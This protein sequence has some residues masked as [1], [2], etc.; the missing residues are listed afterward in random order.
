MWNATEDSP[1][2]AVNS[3]S[4]FF[5]MDSTLICRSHRGFSQR[6]VVLSLGVCSTAWLGSCESRLACSAAVETNLAVWLSVSVVTLDLANADCTSAKL[7]EHTSE[8]PFRWEASSSKS[9]RPSARFVSMKL[10][11]PRSECGSTDRKYF[12]PW[13]SCVWHRIFCWLAHICQ[14]W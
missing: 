4:S 14:V 11:I 1:G 10:R 13:S 9:S 8:G 2:G 12:C 7:N 6:H 5:G 3:Y